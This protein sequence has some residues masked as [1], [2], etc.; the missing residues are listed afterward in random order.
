MGQPTSGQVVM[1]RWFHVDAFGAGDFSISIPIAGFAA[2]DGSDLESNGLIP[3]VEL[4]YDL[5]AALRGEDNWVS[6]A[7]RSS[8]SQ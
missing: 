2:A 8:V 4:H 6:E 5:E 3:Q 1:A 7:A